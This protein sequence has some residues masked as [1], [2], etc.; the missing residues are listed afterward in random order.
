[1]M[2]PRF[3]MHFERTRSLEG[4]LVYDRQNASGGFPESA[5]TGRMLSAAATQR[6]F[7]CTTFRL[8]LAANRLES[9]AKLQPCRLHRVAKDKGAKNY[10]RL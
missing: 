5:F 10:A 3:S 2:N 7:F 9:A 8:I 4:K 6:N 1:M